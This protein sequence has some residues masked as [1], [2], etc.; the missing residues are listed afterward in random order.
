MEVTDPAALAIWQSR[1][2]SI[3]DEMGLTLGRA[4]YS[5]NIKERRDYSCALFDGEGRL[6]AQAAHIPVHLGA[7]PLSVASAI[8]RCAP[9]PGDVVILND[10]FLGG[11]HL[12]DVTLVSATE[13]NGLRFYLASRAHHSDIGG[14]APGSLPLSQEIYQEGLIIPPVHLVRGGV[15]QQDLLALILRNVRTPEERRGD[16]DAQLAAHATGARRLSEVAETAGNAVIAAMARALIAYGERLTRAVIAELPDGAY[17]FED[18]LDDDGQGSG[19]LPICL[20]LKIDG[21]RTIWDFGGTAPAVTGNLNTVRAVTQAAV[22]YAVR[23]LLP[24]GAPTNAG[25]FAPI[26][27]I[28]PEGCLLDALPYHGV[29]AGNMETSQRVVDVAL[30]ALAQALPDRIPAASQGS[31]NNLTAG[32]WDTERARPYA[33]YETSAGGSGAWNGGDGESA[34]HTHMTNT[35]NTP[36]EALEY[37]YPLR[38]RAVRIRPASGG[39]GRFR[40][41]DGVVRSL[42]FLAPA[43]VSLLTERR[44]RAPYGLAGGVAGAPGRNTINRGGQTTT[45]PGKATFSVQAGD[46]VTLETP[47]GGGWGAPD[48]EAGSL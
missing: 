9:Q 15:M 41:G 28:I 43:T 7:M 12:P 25:C 46:V 10:P 5:P 20:R 45:L 23:C 40:G 21:D 6:L 18:A 29:A 8:A 11:T 26:E 19:P 34:V 13:V 30:G 22:Y 14:M 48:A 44:L 17:R 31:M 27:V 3:A 33:Y 42:E 2:A 32:G 39:A 37:A 35:L 4:A 1:F 24:S 16:L 47:G 38:V 36:V